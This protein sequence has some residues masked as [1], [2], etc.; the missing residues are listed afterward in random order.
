MAQEVTGIAT[1]DAIRISRERV[2]AAAREHLHPALAETFVSMLSEGTRLV[3]VTGDPNGSPPVGV[4]GGD[5]LLAPGSVWPT[6]DGRGPLSH[7][8]T[9]DCA[10]LH[11]FLSSALQTAGFPS[12]GSMLFLYFDGAVDDGV[13][14]VGNLF[15]TEAGARVVYLPSTDGLVPASAPEGVTVYRRTE[16]TA[17][18]VLTWPTWEHPRLHLNDNAAPENGWD[19]LFNV[20]DDVR[21]GQPGAAQHQVGGHPYPVQGPVENEV[22]FGILSHG[23][24]DKSVSWTDPDVRA[25]ADTWL[26]LAQIDTDSDIGF[27]WGDV[28]V[29]YWLIK[30]SDLADQLFDR[31]G[32]T[33][34]CG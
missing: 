27:L 21:Q 3:P 13:E 4:L 14:V 29:L 15:G 19:P 22:A 16:I 25:D 28:G 6:W 12:T 17:T 11:L 10:A 1:T 24:T 33:W 2:A 34:Q 30:P 26:L 31:V 8:A 7:I 32:F 9:L 20:L 23:G 18:S 5:P